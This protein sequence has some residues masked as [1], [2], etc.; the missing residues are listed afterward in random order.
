MFVCL[1]Y[2]YLSKENKGDISFA[3]YMLVRI[4]IY[5][6]NIIVKAAR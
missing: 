6:E 5:K 3:A 1:L 2:F 4:V